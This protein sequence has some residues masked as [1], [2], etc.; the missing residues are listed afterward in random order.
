MT[1]LNLSKCGNS[2]TFKDIAAM[3]GRARLYSNLLVSRVFQCICMFLG[4]SMC[5]IGGG[6]CVLQWDMCV[7]ICFSGYDT[8]DDVE[9]GWIVRQVG[10]WS[11]SKCRWLASHLPPPAPGFSCPA[12]LWPE[13]SVSICF[14]C[15]PPVPCDCNSGMECINYG[16]I[17]LWL[18]AGDLQP[19]STCSW[20]PYSG[21][22]C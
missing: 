4:A 3:L 20:F 2:Y 21:S 12:T 19:P 11:A 15:A 18:D 5:F 16:R 17:R 6:V 1:A 7:S 22:Y 14:P 10:C 8:G 9:W 13:C